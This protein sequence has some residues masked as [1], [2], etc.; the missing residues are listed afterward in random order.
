[1][2]ALRQVQAPV[3]RSARAVLGVN[4]GGH[5]LLVELGQRLVVL[6]RDQVH[7]VG[8]ALAAVPDRHAAALLSV[9]VPLS[10]VEDVQYLRRAVSAFEEE[11]AF[12]DRRPE[13]RSH[14][15]V[16]RLAV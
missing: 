6:D 8:D 7:L 15:A 3:Y 13:P 1:M 4:G 11:V 9:F 14:K 10:D 16:K 5:R 12:E 2:S